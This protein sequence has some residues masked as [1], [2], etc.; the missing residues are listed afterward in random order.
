MI[1]KN[2][3]K[4]IKIA[5]SI[6]GEGHG[7][8]G[9][10]IE[11]IKT[12]SKKLPNSQINLYLY[13][14]TLNIFSMV[15]DMPFN[16]KIK[17]IPG[18]RFIYEK[19]SGFKNL[20]ATIRNTGNLAVGIRILKLDFLHTVI[21]PITKIVAIL[22]KQPD[23]IRLRYYM[24]HFEQFDFAIADLEPLLPRVAVLRKKPFLTMDNQHLM[25]FADINKKEFSLKERILHSFIKFSMKIYHPLSELT[26]TTSFFKLPIKKK[27][28]EKVKC[29][30]PLIREE[31]IKIKNEI[32][33]GDY[34]LV[35]AHKVIRDKLFPI[36][37][38]LGHQKYVVFTT[39]DHEH[40]DF[41]YKRDWIEYHSIDPEKF[42]RFFAKCKAVISTAGNTLISEA[43]YL[44]KPFFGISLE[45]NFEQTLNL[46]ML[47]KSN[48]G[49]GGKIIDI[50]QEHLK[51]FFDNIEK[52]QSNFKNIEIKS[53]TEAI[54]DL[55]IKKI[56]RD[57]YEEPSKYHA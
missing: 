52:Y 39:D 25:L 21:F 38:D 3:N 28:T 12:L 35:Y 24:K 43:F 41:I 53:D 6:C 11:I 31:I 57:I 16:V 47:Q 14:E 20:R 22:K 17:K 7:H 42:G 56:K 2:E 36:L 40:K 8:F 26:L 1:L 50:S 4:K 10:N 19:T 30:G 46:H 32:E 48:L 34:I 45:G 44:K 37:T 9:R 54:V 27:F 49:E 33:Y 15:K 23:L 13:G 55:M 18:F 5:Y 29:F 51:H